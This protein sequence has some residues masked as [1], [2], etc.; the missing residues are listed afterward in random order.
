[1]FKCVTRFLMALSYLLFATF[2]VGCSEDDPTQQSSQTDSDSSVDGDADSDTDGDADADSDADPDTDTDTDLKEDTES[3]SPVIC[4]VAATDPLPEGCDIRHPPACGDG[5]L[6]QDYEICDDGNTIPGD[7][8]NGRCEIEPNYACDTNAVPCTCASIIVCGNGHLEPGEVCDDNNTK[9]GDGCNATCDEQA[10]GVVCREGELCTKMYACGN[11]RIESGEECEDDDGA[12]PEDGDGCSAECII[13]PGY[14]CLVPNQACTRLPRCGDGQTRYD[15]GEQCD[16]GNADSGDG[17]EADCSNIEKGYECPSAG[18]DCTLIPTEC[19]NGVLDWDEECDDNNSKNNDGCT[20]TCIEENGYT[21]PYQGA[22]CI[23]DCGD[24]IQ[25]ASEACDDGN[26]DNTDGCTND[27]Q[28]EEGKTCKYIKPANSDTYDCVVHACGDGELG[29][30]W[31]TTLACDDQN[32]EVGD[33][34]SPLCQKEPLC[35]PGDGCTSECGDGIVIAPETCDD[36][37]NRN[38]DGC[39]EDCTQEPGYICNVDAPL[40]ESIDVLVIYKDFVDGDLSGDFENQTIIN[41]NIES[42]GMVE[43]ELSLST[44]KPVLNSNYGN[45]TV[46]GPYEN[47]MH[48]NPDECDKNSGANNFALWYDHMASDQDAI[49]IDTITLWQN[50]EGDYV[51]VWLDDGTRWSTLVTDGEQWCAN[52]AADAGTTLAECETLC[53]GAGIGYDP[54]DPNWECRPQCS[55]GNNVCAFYTDAGSGRSLFD[56]NPVFFPIDGKG[57]SAGDTNGIGK[58][59]IPG[60]V[61]DGNWTDEEMYIANNALDVPAGYTYTH[62]FLFTSEIR[63]WFKYDSAAS[64]SLNF[65]GDDDVWVFVNGLLALDIGGL[66]IP[67]EKEFTLQDLETSHG[68]EDGKVY[69]IVVFQAERQRDGS[70]Y[71]LTLGGFNTEPSQCVPDCGDG[72]ITVGEQCDNG[73]YNSDTTYNGCTTTC[74]LGP[75]CGDGTVQPGED[76]DNGV[77]TD[78]YGIVGNDSCAP[79]CKFPEYCGDGVLQAQFG[80]QCDDELGNTGAY[81]ACGSD[82]ARGPFCGDGLITAGQEI[83]DIAGTP[84]NASGNAIYACIDCTHGPRCGDNIVQTEWGEECDGAAVDGQKCTSECRFEGNCGDE[85]VDTVAGEKCDYGISGNDGSYGGCTP[86]CLFAPR[87][88]DGV[89]QTEQGEV[90]D[91]GDGLNNGDYGGCGP[92]CQLGPYCGDGIKQDYF[93][94]CDEGFQEEPG[95]GIYPDNC[96]NTCKAV[97]VPE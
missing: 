36:G 76:C 49:I 71:K 34:C 62:N 50:T 85:I 9:D 1:M 86:G 54:D 16:D 67:I 66:H 52:A 96:S 70:S 45:P 11:G 91:S 48:T 2:F 14:E 39:A 95:D 82:C 92:D 89:V 80:E 26:D 75:R 38:G 25:I 79:N 63:F 94:D 84:V 5:I 13:E 93:E 87:C 31:R 28:W 20:D 21:C 23:P 90:C 97:T 4:I 18:G 29:A 24:G 88:G 41:C 6:N 12:T 44:G 30:L 35:T 10:D 32:K 59:L 3:G 58:A 68:L 78:T 40:G 64:Q 53:S 65:V 73:T 17:C 22:P 47:G 33:G 81:G 83:C 19:G 43:E 56:G 51:N 27:C 57:I 42:A 61:Y 7:G 77:N 74:E 55:Y 8:A 69:E 46:S 37:N 72:V 60:P 15:L